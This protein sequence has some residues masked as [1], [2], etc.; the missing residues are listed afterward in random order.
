M[1]TDS[2]GARLHEHAVYDIDDDIDKRCCSTCGIYFA[3][4]TK[5]TEHQRA[6]HHTRT[7][8]TRKLRPSR[9]VTRRV[10]EFLHVSDNGLEWLIQSEIEGSD[11]F[12][13]KYLDMLVSVV[14]LEAV[15]ESPWTKL[16]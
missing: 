11:D 12:I 5:V 6:A 3:S 13:E 9:I 2:T 15:Q 7:V 1:P 16:E 4:I 10:T 8:Q 14:T